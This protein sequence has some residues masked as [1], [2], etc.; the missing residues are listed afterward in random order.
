MTDDPLMH[1]LLPCQEGTRAE[2]TCTYHD[3]AEQTLP[4]CS[5]APRLGLPPA[6]L[7]HEKALAASCLKEHPPP[8]ACAQPHQPCDAE[9]HSEL[10]RGAQLSQSASPEAA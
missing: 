9:S 1:P 2:T 7:P 5:E 10:L 3:Q 4:I 6:C 8:H